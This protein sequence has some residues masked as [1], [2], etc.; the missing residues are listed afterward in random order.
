MFTFLNSIILSVLFTAFIPLLIHLFNKQKTKKIKFSSL[1][2]L[3][4]LEKRRLKKVK[5]YQI[6]LI[7][8]RTILIV[9]LVLAFARPTFSG[10]WSILQKSSASTTAVVILD[11][12]LN[13]RQYDTAGNRFNRA[14]IKLKNI[15]KT[16]KPE[17]RVRLLKSTTTETDLLDS[18]G[19]RDQ[20]CSY[21]IGDIDSKF[22]K[23]L[24][25]FKKNPNLNK[26]IHLISDM[27]TVT[28]QIGDFSNNNKDIKIYLEKIKEKG[29]G[30][31]S[32]DN[33]EF[34][35][36]LF[37][38][39]KPLK[40]KVYLRNHSTDKPMNV[41][42]HLYINNKRMAQNSAVISAG[43]VQS[44]KLT[45]IPKSF[46]WNIGYIEINDDDLLEDNK[47]YFS[48]N[49]PEKAKVLFV[50]NE[51]SPIWESA[52]ESINQSTN[53]EIFKENYNSL[54]RQSLFDYDV[55]FL[56]NL[57]EIS[58]SMLSRINTYLNSGGGLITVL[59]DKTVPSSFNSN[60]GPILGNLKIV[61]LNQTISNS[62][63]FTL[64]Q[65]EKNN[66]IISEIF[67]KDDPEISLPKFKKYFK[68]SN[69][70][71]FQN[72]IEFNDGNPFIL[73]SNSNQF[74]AIVI[75]SYFNDSW[76]DMHYKGI[77]IPLL[78]RTIKYAAYNLEKSG[79]RI[80]AGDE[81]VI[82]TNQ[83]NSKQVF[84]LTTPQGEKNRITPNFSGSTI[85]FDLKDFYIPGNYIIQ[86]EKKI[87]SVVSVNVDSK[88]LGKN[89]A[90]IESIVDENKNI[91]L[92]N[93]NEK[94]NDK[95]KTA[96]FGEEFWK[97]LIIFVLLILLIET[98]VVKKLEGKL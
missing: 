35:N 42:M 90:D 69:A 62:A 57:P 47:Y 24:K 63:Y 82:S 87:I 83:K 17:D 16:F 7:I 74:N 23:A 77:F 8:I 6:L 1:R 22:R 55:L 66:P 71:K 81:V 33:L 12:G 11:D 37:E 27:E 44:F 91:E 28:K 93:E 78:L 95:L 79:N 85:N 45:F 40:V 43:K 94:I 34:E 59:G 68:L 36:K 19:I 20:E 92:I 88:R 75:S 84:E 52:I 67:R 4:K 13:M 70:G 65:I 41:N 10:A 26:E 60:I 96:R 32:I 39:N 46:D 30:N 25:Y 86:Q 31:I 53:I 72:I 98:F 29:F 2:F 49:I 73:Y 56:N 21:L 38:I 3:K 76:S 50:N 54:A 80:L 5:I 15:L 9:L 51:S 14:T 58:N 61:N 18:L 97:Y 89:Q 48:I 64:K